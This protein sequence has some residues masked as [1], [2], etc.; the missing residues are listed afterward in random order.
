MAQIVAANMA[1]TFVSPWFAA[2]SGATL[3]GRKYDKYVKFARSF[4]KTLP[5]IWS[6]LPI[7]HL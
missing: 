6:R 7:N 5:F 2:L 1:A 4:E 3:W